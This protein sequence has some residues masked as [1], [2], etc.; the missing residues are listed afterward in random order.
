MVSTIRPRSR[1]TFNCSDDVSITWPI[2]QRWPSIGTSRCTPWNTSRTSAK[3]SA[4]M[5]L[6]RRLCSAAN[7][8]RRRK[9]AGG[10]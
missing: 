8:T 1:I 10:L 4:T 3:Q 6:T 2:I 9:R 5:V 7:L